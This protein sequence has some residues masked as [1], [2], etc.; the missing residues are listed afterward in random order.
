MQDPIADCPEKKKEQQQ[1]NQSQELVLFNKNQSEPDRAPFKLLFKQYLEHCET[2]EPVPKS[3]LHEY[4]K[5]L[6]AVSTN[7]ELSPDKPVELCIGADILDCFDASQEEQDKKKRLLF[8]HKISDIKIVD[9]IQD[10]PAVYYEHVIDTTNVR[11]V[12]FRSKSKIKIEFLNS[13]LMDMTVTAN[14]IRDSSDSGEESDGLLEDSDKEQSSSASS[15]QQR[16]RGKFPRTS[17]VTKSKK[18]KTQECSKKTKYR[19]DTKLSGHLPVSPK[20]S[21]DSPKYS[22]SSESDLDT[23]EEIQII[24]LTMA[25]SD[26]SDVE[27]LEQLPPVEL[28]EHPVV[29]IDDDDD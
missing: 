23:R 10:H 15:S 21:P 14:K 24:D 8:R 3:Y 29:E 17:D 28:R 1:C 16:Q 20:Y 9:S 4:G 2:I 19:R 11:L 13:I 5:I 12:Y 22:E 25:Y 18:K 26:I 7:S 27:V 6:S